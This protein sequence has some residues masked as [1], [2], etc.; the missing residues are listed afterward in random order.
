MTWCKLHTDI[1]SDAKLL[2]AARKGARSLVIL[3]WL[4]VW[5]REHDPTDGGRIVLGG[6]AAE[7]EDIAAALPAVSAKQ[8]E[9]CQREAEAIGVLVRDDDGVLRFAA[10]EGR[11]GKGS[12]KPS[13]HPDAVR[14]R[15]QRHRETKRNG[16]NA[17][18]ADG[19]GTPETLA[20]DSTLVV[21]PNGNAPE[22]PVTRYETPQNKSKSKSK[23]EKESEKEK[24]RSDAD[25]SA[26]GGNAAPAPDEPPAPA[27]TIERPAWLVLHAEW[28]QRIGSIDKGRFR[29]AFR[30]VCEP[31]GGAPL[32]YPVPV[33]RTALEWY[34]A[35]RRG[36]REW[37][38]V[39]PEQ[40]VGGITEHI[41]VARMDPQDRVK[42]LPL[43]PAGAA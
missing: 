5:A 6:D 37:G 41:R 38:F 39:K 28:E 11:S 42:L 35:I 3:P 34:A 17:L 27:A 43:A 26:G 2:R 9:A 24:Q 20:S 30:T 23:S 25:A 31:D 19:N 15:V 21:S 7:P 32:P 18:H 36:T 14:V 22:T 4:M 40:F 13:D 1:L 16:A 12:A 33:L 8:V 29:R 10:W